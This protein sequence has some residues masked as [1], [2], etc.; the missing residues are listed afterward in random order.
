MRRASVEVKVEPGPKGF[1]ED[2]DAAK[3]LRKEIIMPAL[4]EDKN[5]VI[6]FGGVTSSTQSF[7]HALVGE[8]LQTIGEEVLNKLEFR[9]C[10]PQI[11]SLVELVVDYSLGGFSASSSSPMEVETGAKRSGRRK[12]R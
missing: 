12:R 11:K 2:K 1:V 7:V 9:S 5:V 6:N 3:R 10:A 4:R 8:P